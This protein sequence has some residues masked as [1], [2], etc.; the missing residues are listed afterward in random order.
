MTRKAVKRTTR[1]TSRKPASLAEIRAKL[2]RR[3]ALFVEVDGLLIELRAP[4][5]RQVNQVL[6]PF[7]KDGGDNPEMDTDRLIGF[8]CAAVRLCL[9]GDYAKLTGPEIEDLIQAGK[10]PKGELVRTAFDLCGL[11]TEA[12]EDPGP[13][14]SRAPRAAA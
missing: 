9:G 2:K 5:W 4:K 8:H 14:G 6:H 3:R 11:R 7:F 10:G 12:A 1:K 13:F